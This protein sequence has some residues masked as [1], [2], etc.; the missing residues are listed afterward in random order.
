M[1]GASVLRQVATV[2]VNKLPARSRSQRAI[3]RNY[4]LSQV[5]GCFGDL[6]G[7]PIMGLHIR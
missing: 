2:G 3:I 4:G 1:W 7:L 5:S 6:K